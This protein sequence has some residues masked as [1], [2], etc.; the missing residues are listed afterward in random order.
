VSRRRTP[1][2]RRADAPPLAAAS[3]APSC[4]N[5]DAPGLRRY[6]AECGQ[7]A[8]AA[9]DYSLRAYAADLAGQVTNADGKLARTLWA[10]VARPGALTADHLRGR[11]ARYLKPLQL[12]LLVNVLL[13]FAAPQVPLFSY[14]LEKYLR[15]APPSPTL[16]GALVRRATP[17]GHTHA[18]GPAGAAFTAYEHRF[19]ARVE[20]QRKSLIILFAPALALVLR[21]VF[22]L[23]RA[24]AGVPRRY[25]EH[26]VFALHTLAF[27]WLVLA[28]AG[29]VTALAGKLPIPFPAGRAAVVAGVILLLLWAPLHLLRAVRRV[30]A[31]SWP[32]AAAAT[33][34]ITFAFLVLLFV[35]RG[36]L[37]FTT[38]YT[39]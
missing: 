14:S 24:R 22:A 2:I 4:P 8:P 9:T 30:Y 28:G 20:A 1:P 35:Y 16:A 33:A 38:W 17:A 36:L 18:T 26:L 21:G 13:F 23:G 15:F 25:G 6:C 31:L 32:R 39:L 11:R 19:D 27:V 37:F 5:C 12:F 34:A 10:L 29:V 3:A 7:A